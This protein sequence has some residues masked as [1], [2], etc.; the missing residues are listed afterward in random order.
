MYNLKGEYT[1]IR[2]GLKVKTKSKTLLRARLERRG[3][4]DRSGPRVG[5]GARAGPG[6]VDRGPRPPTS[7]S[8][9][10]VPFCCVQLFTFTFSVQNPPAFSALF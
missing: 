3:V 2:S 9:P 8:V 1:S 6:G 4:G 7:V 5:R 10:A